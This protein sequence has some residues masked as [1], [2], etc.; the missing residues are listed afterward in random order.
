MPG[1]ERIAYQRGY[2]YQSA[3]ITT[4]LQANADGSCPRPVFADAGLDTWYGAPAW[5]PGDA[6]SGDGPLRC[7]AGLFRSSGV[8]LPGIGRLAPT[9]CGWAGGSIEVGIALEDVLRVEHPRTA[10]NEGVQHIAAIC[11][12]FCIGPPVGPLRQAGPFHGSGLEV[13]PGGGG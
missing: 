6:R 1:G 5:R 2:D 11:P 7:W 9:N 8:A 13:Q 3:Q 12:P 4:V 10:S